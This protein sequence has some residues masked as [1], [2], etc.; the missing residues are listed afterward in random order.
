MLWKLPNNL[1]VSH[2]ET[3]A[4]TVPGVQRGE[5]AVRLGPNPVE[6]ILNRVVG[7]WTKLENAHLS[8]LK[9]TIC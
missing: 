6:S 3:E 9:S 7:V 2:S 4:Q 1:R 8:I 5:G